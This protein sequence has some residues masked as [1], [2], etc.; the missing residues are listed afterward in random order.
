MCVSVNMCTDVCVLIN[1]CLW[2]CVISCK[3]VCFHVHVCV[4]V[5]VCLHVCVYVSGFKESGNFG[6]KLVFDLSSIH[7]TIVLE[8]FMLRNICV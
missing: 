7:I 6:Q 4:H 3:C 1:V 8:I 2:M 5:C